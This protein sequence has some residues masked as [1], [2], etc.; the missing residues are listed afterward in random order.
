VSDSICVC[1]SVCLCVFVCVVCVG[2]SA[3]MYVCGSVYAC[4]GVWVYMCVLISIENK[5]FGKI[6][7]S[8]VSEGKSNYSYII[9]FAHFRA[10][11]RFAQSC[12]KVG[13]KFLKFRGSSQK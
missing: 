8:Y 9:N 5:E 12:A 3:S 4:G 6:P 10:E 2:F 1:V 11:P 7:Y 13:T